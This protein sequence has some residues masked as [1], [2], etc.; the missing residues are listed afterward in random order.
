MIIYSPSK[1]YTPETEA[2]RGNKLSPI[3]MRALRARGILTEEDRERFLHPDLSV[4]RDPFMLPDMQK[5][6]DRIEAALVEGEKICVYGDYDVDGICATTILLQYL[7]SIGAEVM[8][9]IPS[10]QDEGYGISRKA[11]DALNESGVTLIITVDNGISACSEIDYAKQLGIDIIVTDHHI[12]PERIPDCAAVVC[13]SVE[14]SRY[15][16]YLCGAGTALKLIQALGGV[17][18]TEP[19]IYLAGVATVADVVPLVD[20]N[21]LLVKYA[22]DAMNN[23][24]CC[25]GLKM[26]L[27][28][29][30]NAK[31]PYSAFNIGFGI[32]PRLNASGRMGDASLCV[33]LFMTGDHARAAEIIAELNR[34]NELRQAE[35]QAILN[36]AIEMVEKLDVSR[37]HAIL[38]ASDKW[39]SGV[40]GIAA[41]RLTEIYNRPTVLFSEHNGDLKGSARSI[42]GINI[43]DAL[44][45]NSDLFIR[46][47]GHAKA[48]GVTM[49][50]QR[51][52]EFT[53][54][55]E[56]Y[57]AENCSAEL[58]VPRRC[59]EFDEEL[60]AITMEVTTQLETLAPFGEGNPCPVFHASGV[61]ALHLRRFGSDGQHLRMDIRQGRYMLNSVYFCGGRSFERL[62]GADTISLL[63]SPFVNRWNGSDS[64]Q[65]RVTSARP[66]S[67]RCA[68][69]FIKDHMH[70][71]Y[72]ALLCSMAFDYKEA[73]L[74]Q[75]YSGSLPELVKS[76]FA[77][78]MMLVFSTEEAERVLCE[79]GEAGVENYE[80]CFGALPDGVYS[81]NVLIIAPHL[82]RLPNRGY[83]SIVFCDEPYCGGVY[84]CIKK[85]YPGANLMRL[86]AQSDFADICSG[87]TISRAEMGAYYKAVVAAVSARNYSMPELVVHLCDT[88]SRQPHQTVFALMVFKQLGFI[89]DDGGN[90]VRLLS[91]GFRQ[92]DESRVYKFVAQMQQED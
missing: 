14:G 27:D 19:Y 75:L 24:N 70:S 78:L 92:L 1:Y 25:L 74:P 88:L 87:F 69:R 2:D 9:K 66:D 56:K 76:S 65:L 26:L 79:L 51:F 10:R 53:E 18:A 3:V 5:A 28:S 47:G 61:T 62:L 82:S 91:S 60:S 21:R 49:E 33:E 68:S 39:N 50:K 67:P 83:N 37:R 42:E 90:A 16:R 73:P 40:I 32:A 7:Y 34:L 72:D 17:E 44:K 48:A 30:P 41:S 80:I 57:L 13:H 43:H 63:Y 89:T 35:E 12:P 20:E 31:K 54:A 85:S 59:Y 77:G 29:L 71:F 81:D 23:G 38:L 15:P 36:D 4:L 22:L 86:G 64:V 84:G 11:I 45:A 6:A 55:F 52:P 46:F 58:F 8:Y